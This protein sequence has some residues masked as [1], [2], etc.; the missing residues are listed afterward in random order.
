METVTQPNTRVK[1]VF[2]KDD[3]IRNKNEDYIKEEDIYFALTDV[4]NCDN[5][6]GTQ[7]V[8]N[9]WR[10]YINDHG[11]RVKVITSG[12]SIKGK[13]VT[14]YDLNPYIN[15]DENL[16]RV[17]VKDIPLSV[18]NEEITNALKKLGCKIIG[19]IQLI[20]FRIQGKL[21]RFLNGDRAIF[22]ERFKGS[23]PRFIK[24]NNF[25]ARL[26]HKDQKFEITCFECG[27]TG[28][29][30]N[31]CPKKMD[32]IICHK[33]NMSGHFAKNCKGDK[34]VGLPHKLVINSTNTLPKLA[35]NIT[36]WIDNEEEYPHEVKEI[37]VGMGEE[38]Q[39]EV[40]IEEETL[41]NVEEE[42]KVDIEEE[43]EEE[44]E[45]ILDIIEEENKQD[46][47]T[48]NVIVVLEELLNKPVMPTNKPESIELD[49]KVQQ[50]MKEAIDRV[51]T[52]NQKDNEKM[53]PQDQKN[54]KKKQRKRDKKKSKQC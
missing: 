9:L 11:E 7:K 49:E 41:M 8:K 37:E 1:P 51:K 35:T 2:V 30:I 50:I 18:R 23:L 32:S 45:K 22:V 48:S 43:D 4:I 25:S 27:L 46:E 29:K 53:Q 54:E 36:K 31:E 16:I 40:D 24:V 52:I 33:C 20:K 47:A 42:E 14:V 3:D 12:L 10:I 13:Q 19:E 28:H 15:A 21:S 26:F 6:I 5:L 34:Y 38:V 39:V 17:L 44:E